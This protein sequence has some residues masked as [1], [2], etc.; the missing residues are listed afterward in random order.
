MFF[1][2][3]NIKSDKLYDYLLSL[4]NKPQ[5][6]IKHF[7]FDCIF[8]DFDWVYKDKGLNAIHE[9]YPIKQL[10]FLKVSPNS[11]YDW[12]KDSYRLS[13]VNMLIKHQHSHCL[14]GTIRDEHY[15][16]ITEL[17]YKPYTFYIFNNQQYHSVLNLDQSR[18]LFSLYFNKE[19]DY[20]L[21]KDI[22]HPILL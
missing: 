11:F 12:H 7:G 1:N 3:T 16:N 20:N 18:Y 4:T 10:G 9:L 2:P 14:F 13:T 5:N 17:N 6:W 21:L 15:I 22:L 19:L 8:I